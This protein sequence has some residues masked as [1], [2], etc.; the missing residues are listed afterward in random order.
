MGVYIATCGQYADLPEPLSV[1]DP[2]YQSVKVEL[3]SSI[4]PVSC[5]AASHAWSWCGSWTLV[6]LGFL[7]ADDGSSYRPAIVVRLGAWV[8]SWFILEHVLGLQ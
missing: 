6:L 2:D 8:F 5:L 7:M 3:S 1:V 4:S